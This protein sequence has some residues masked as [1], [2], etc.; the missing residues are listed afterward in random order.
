MTQKKCNKVH[1]QYGMQYR[2]RSEKF[3][4][5]RVKLW[6]KKDKNRRCARLLF[7][8]WKGVAADCILTQ[9]RKKTAEKKTN[10]R[11]G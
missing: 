10:Q 8:L 9:G 11:K 7:F 3:N 2:T 4:C 5:V 1:Q 6:L